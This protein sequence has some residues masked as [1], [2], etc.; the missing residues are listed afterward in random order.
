MKIRAEYKGIVCECVRSPKKNEHFNINFDG[1]YLIE[2]YFNG[3]T[4]KPTRAIDGWGERHAV[5]LSELK[6]EKIE[7]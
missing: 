2:F 1:N 5:D 3:E 4:F 7:D 6:I